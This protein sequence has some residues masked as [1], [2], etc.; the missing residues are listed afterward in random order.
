MKNMDK[1]N[2]IKE[3][4]ERESKQYDNYVLCDNFTK[5]LYFEIV[6][7]GEIKNKYPES[8][9]KPHFHGFYTI[10]WFKSGKGIHFVDSEVY[11]IK[12]GSI[13]FLNPNQ[14]HIVKDYG[15]NDGIVIAFSEKMFDLICPR[16]AD[17]IRY[18]IFSRQG[19]CLFCDTDKE[20]DR[21]LGGILKQ[22]ALE[23]KKTESYGYEY[24]IPALLT[25]F[26][27]QAE[28]LCNWSQDVQRNINSTSYKTYLNFISLIDANFKEEK[29]VEWYA[30]KMG[31]SVVLLS[32]YVKKYNCDT[33]TTP[34]K[35]I[36]NK[37]FLEAERMLKHS[38]ESVS[39]IAYHL[40]FDDDSNFI[41]FFKKLDKKQRTPK[42]YRENWQV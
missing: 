26:V 24:I 4:K 20:A 40:G 2:I 17:Y 38:T 11:A 34:L 13:F 3:K 42:Q 33:N 31:I 28:R 32:R 10:Q 29:K 36:N 22:M 39:R 35:M 21:V 25:E 41:K 37:V 6:P 16:L 12:D 30:R 18:E 1:N 14:L 27:I 9:K 23:S 8:C 5:N 7:M 19:K 15:L